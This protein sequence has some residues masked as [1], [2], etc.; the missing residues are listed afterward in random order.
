MPDDRLRLTWSVRD[1]GGN[2][3]ESNRVL[4]D[5]GRL[6]RE[7]CAARFPEE[8]GYQVAH[9]RMSG[10]IEGSS[11]HVARGAF[12]ALVSVQRFERPGCDG[13]RA[14]EIRV[15]ASASREC[16]TALARPERRYVQWGIAGCAAGTVALGMAALQIAGQ[17][18]TWAHVLALIPALMAWRMA[19]AMRLATE[20]KRQSA[21]PL[22]VDH[23]SPEE[24][25]ARQAEEER[26]LEVLA[27]VA[28]QRDATSERFTC[29][30]F[31]SPGAVPGTIA[32]FVEPPITPLERPRALPMPTLAMPPLGRTTAV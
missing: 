24:L 13:A 7:A 4:A 8:S 17:L 2:E 19:M 5:L 32:A 27:I 20:L 12:R 18:S 28:A 16:V 14:T 3:A 30:G 31:R 22:P 26:W 1:E 21:L 9:R 23:T 25:A 6:C 29:R 15:V 10:A 11:T